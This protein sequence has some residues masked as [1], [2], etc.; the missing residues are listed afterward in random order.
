MSGDLEVTNKSARLWGKL[1]INITIKIVFTRTRK[2]VGPAVSAV[3][4]LL[5]TFVIN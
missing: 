1:S 5:S 3:A 4:I 2:S